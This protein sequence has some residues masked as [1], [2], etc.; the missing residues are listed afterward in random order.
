[1]H[2]KRLISFNCPSFP[3]A[4]VPCLLSR[5]GS[6]NVYKCLDISYSSIRPFVCRTRRT[7]RRRALI[8]DEMGMRGRRTERF[9]LRPLTRI[10]E[11][12]SYIQLINCCCQNYPRLRGGVLPPPPPP[13]V[14]FINELQAW[15]CAICQRRILVLVV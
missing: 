11:E 15:T 13:R 14:P 8:D 9:F 10:L 5:R 3:N 4:N 6:F 12:I 1:M 2:Y 7:R